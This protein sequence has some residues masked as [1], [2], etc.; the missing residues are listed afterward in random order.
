MTGTAGARF[1]QSRC[2]FN[3][4][5]AVDRPAVRRA[6]QRHQLL[7]HGRD[8][9]LASCGHHRPPRRRRAGRSDCHHRRTAA[10]RCRRHRL[11]QNRFISI[12]GINWAWRDWRRT[13]VWRRNGLRGRLPE[14]NTG[15]RGQ[16]RSARASC[17]C[18]VLAIAAYATISGVF[19]SLRVGLDG[20]T[21]LDVKRF[22]A[23]TQSL[24]D[25]TGTDTAVVAAALV[26]SPLLLFA[27]A[28]GGR[29]VRAWQSCRR[30]RRW[31]IG[32]R[33]LAA[34]RPRAR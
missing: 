8:L 22:G 16:R 24:T 14:P 31:R 4:R 7:H 32:C 6:R 15:A 21:A 18:I 10:R 17:L 26:A 9:G 33:R 23:A 1:S 30:P 19:G 13:A 11:C 34:D 20:A 5:R 29:A 25:L 28:R 27:I 12:R 3:G 2:G